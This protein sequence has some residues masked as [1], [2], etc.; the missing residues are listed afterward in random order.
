MAKGDEPP[1]LWRIAAPRH[2]TTLHSQG[3]TH[4]PDPGSRAS[5][6]RLLIAALASP[7]AASPAPPASPPPSPR[8]TARPDNVKMD[9][10]RKP[11][12]G[13]A[14]PRAAARNERARPVR[15][16]QILVGDHGAGGRA[17]GPG[18][19]LGADPVPRPTSQSAFAAFAAKR[20]M[21]SIDLEP[22]R[23]A[24]AAQRTPSTS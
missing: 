15:R 17:Q 14:V 23:S 13:A 3:G 22:V 12:R 11:A 4:A 5:T 9:E 18:D 1:K 2:R 7:P 10:S 19:R 16:Q 21:S 24:D 6:C 8:P 20:R